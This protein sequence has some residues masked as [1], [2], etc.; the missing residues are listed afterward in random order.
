M[1]ITPEDVPQSAVH[2]MKVEGSLLSGKHPSQPVEE[3]PESAREFN[4]ANE[5]KMEFEEKERSKTSEISDNV[6]VEGRDFA[7]ELKDSAVEKRN[8]SRAMSPLMNA[9]FVSNVV[10]GMDDVSSALKKVQQD[11]DNDYAK[12][13][14]PFEKTP[15]SNSPPKSNNSTGFRY[16]PDHGIVN[17]ALMRARDANRPSLS[18]NEHMSKEVRK[19]FAKSAE[20][21]LR[22]ASGEAASVDKSSN[23][24]TQADKKK[25][26]AVDMGESFT[27]ESSKE[28][29][30]KLR[31][32]SYVKEVKM[33]H[34][35]KERNP[36]M[37]CCNH[38]KCLWRCNPDKRHSG[39]GELTVG[40]ASCK[41]YFHPECFMLDSKTFIEESCKYDWK[42]T[43]CKKC[44]ICNE[45]P[46][47]HD[48]K[49]LLCDKCD[50]GFHMFCLTPS[51]SDF[52]QGEWFCAV[53][54]P[55]KE[56]DALN[57]ESAV[58]SVTAVAEPNPA[59]DTVSESADETA[60]YAELPETKSV[61]KLVT[62][63]EP[64]ENIT[65][66]RNIKKPYELEKG[67]PKAP[68]VETV[69]LTVVAKAEKEQVARESKTV[70]LA[71]EDSVGKL[72]NTVSPPEHAERNKRKQPVAIETRV[73]QEVALNLK[74]VP[75]SR[76]F[77]VDES[78]KGSCDAL[79]EACGETMKQIH[80]SQ[81]AKL[82][83]MAPNRKP[84]DQVDL[85]IQKANEMVDSMHRENGKL[86]PRLAK[87]LCDS[88]T[89]A[90]NKKINHGCFC[91]KRLAAGTCLDCGECGRWFH[92]GCLK[93]YEHLPKN[94]SLEMIEAFICGN[95][96]PPNGKKVS[97]KKRDYGV[98][99]EE[100]QAKKPKIG[101]MRKTSI[102]R[103]PAAP[104]SIAELPRATYAKKSA[105][106]GNVS[107][108]KRNV[109]I[110]KRPSPVFG[111]R[112]EERGM[113]PRPISSH[114]PGMLEERLPL[115][116][117]PPP[118]PRHYHAPPL[119]RPPPMQNERR[120]MYEPR[121][122][123][124]RPHV[125]YDREYAKYGDWRR[126]SITRGP[127][128]S[129]EAPMYPPRGEERYQQQT[130]RGVVTHP[131]PVGQSGAP[132]YILRPPR[133]ENV[134]EKSLWCGSV[135]KS[136]SFVCNV[137]VM[138][139]DVDFPFNPFSHLDEIA[140]TLITGVENLK[141]LSPSPNN[142]FLVQL[143]PTTYQCSR[144]YEGLFE[145]LTERNSVGIVKIEPN[146]KL[147]VIPSTPEVHSLLGVYKPDVLL[148]MFVYE[149]K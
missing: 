33:G 39:I 50:R 48:D 85:I 148:G 8:D 29:P 100:T 3:K 110:E 99:P 123:E 130:V 128:V 11:I 10:K 73:S 32:G 59:E 42:C 139:F 6:L 90:E 31:R 24:V 92:I 22:T 35:F 111:S 34:Q 49:V 101:A 61:E 116:E 67:I 138:G 103:E 107:P 89:R 97:V 69:G 105:G 57:T 27:S 12:V 41:L 52:P 137:H 125:V 126:N 55:P 5:D 56:K 129:Y 95:C 26:S 149:G 115:Y 120:T 43:E 14:L 94:A 65:E 119:P 83:Q 74:N 146:M 121:Y 91:S 70:N 96:L 2:P 38:H 58:S 77:P 87:K 142:A 28:S 18:S 124:P 140:I 47:E 133:S 122:A 66:D 45:A 4:S 102:P 63:T 44:T 141:L 132:C 79:L 30:S 147:Y 76:P 143:T 113:H 144:F 20:R 51:V 98:K 112:P 25:D 106:S 37:L 135:K 108:R 46:R 23:S 40:C 81:K 72:Q 127:H 109:A 104:V 82:D 80:R 13:R 145:Y 75:E 15:N 134:V 71:P 84:G 78:A 16:S 36:R 1:D 19:I 114:M 68:E 54:S 21:E 118:D 136:N 60:P 86:I 131:N 88:S 9:S 53:C 64:V 117:R 62:A 7:V 93:Q 17:K